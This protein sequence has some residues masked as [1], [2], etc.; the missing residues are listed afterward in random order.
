MTDARYMLTLTVTGSIAVQRPSLANGGPL[1][2]GQEHW[3][4]ICLPS[5]ADQRPDGQVLFSMHLVE[6]I[7]LPFLILSDATG[8]P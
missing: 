8:Y 1:V 4:F 2:G 7:L 3:L 6:W 5:H